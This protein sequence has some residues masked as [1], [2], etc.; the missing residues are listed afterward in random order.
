MDEEWTDAEDERLLD[1]V[2]S[3]Q[4]TS[5][6]MKSIVG[7]A[8][9]VHVARLLNKPGVRAQRCLGRFTFL[10]SPES[11]ERRASVR[12]RAYMKKFKEKKRPAERNLTFMRQL[13][14]HVKNQCAAYDAACIMSNMGLQQ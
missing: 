1:E 10:A 4:V 9:W 5:M 3:V 8:Q 14:Q 6:N 7:M 11:G 13:V 12:A 2:I